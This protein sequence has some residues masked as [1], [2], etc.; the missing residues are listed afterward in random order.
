V[1]STPIQQIELASEDPTS[2]IE[3]IY[4]IWLVDDLDTPGYVVDGLSI[5]QISVTDTQIIARASASDM[6]NRTFP[7]VLYTPA[8]FPGLFHV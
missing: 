8:M 5:S 7:T 3:M 1:E 2:T 6:L 4:R